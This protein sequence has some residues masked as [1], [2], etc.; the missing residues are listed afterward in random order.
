[1]QKRLSL[2][3]L[4]VT[5]S[6]KKHAPLYL[7]SLSEFLIQLPESGSQ[8]TSPDQGLSPA[9]SRPR[10]ERAFVRGWRRDSFDCKNQKFVQRSKV[11][12]LAKLSEV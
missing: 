12:H 8:V 4:I 2:S 5:F 11:I 3:I 6:N 7:L 10:E 1:M 9:S